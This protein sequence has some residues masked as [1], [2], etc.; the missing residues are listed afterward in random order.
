MTIDRREFL[1][2]VASSALLT[3]GGRSNTGAMGRPEQRA[4]IVSEEWWLNQPITWIQTNL[5]VTDAALDPEKF[6]DAIA[7]FNGNALVIDMGGIF[8]FYPSQ[9]QF[10]RVSPYM[11]KGQDMF[12]EVLRLARARSIRVIGRFDFSK[13]HKDAYIAHHDWFFLKLNGEP[14]IYNDLY[15]TCI[16]GGWYHKKAIEILNEA[17]NRYEVDGLFFNMFGNS[18]RDYSGNPLGL[19]HCAN[20]EEL[21]WKQFHR[22]IPEVPDADY[23]AFMHN[24][25]V[26]VSRMVRSL[27]KAKR[28][29]AALVGTR[30][31][32]IV[33]SESNTA[34]NRPLPLWPYSASDNVNRG[35]NT[36]PQK[37]V[38]NSCM[39]FID[40][41]WRFAM[42]PP[43]EIATRLWQNVANGG[44]PAFT[45]HGT[46]AE[47]EDQTALNVARPIFRQLKEH[48]T[49]YV[50]QYPV[51]RVLLLGAG[52]RGFHGDEDAYRGFFRLLSEDHLPFGVVDNLD[53]L[54]KRAVDLIVA[55]GTVPS[56]LGEWVRNGGHLLM[57][58]ST[59]PPMNMGKVVKVWKDPVGAY[60]RIRDKAMFPSMKDIDIIFMYG[61][62]LQVD[63]KG[64]ITF[65]PPAMFGPPELVDID[66]K[67][68]ED[69]GLIVAEYGKG[70]IAWL[71]WDLGTLYYRQSSE[72]HAL[73]IHDLIDYLLP[74]GRQLRTNAHPL[75][76]ITLMKQGDHHLIHLV[77]ISGHSDTAYFKAIGISKIK[78]EVKGN[79][80]S[81][82]AVMSGGDLAVS[83]S[84]GYTGFVVPTLVDYELINIR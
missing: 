13:A 6:I 73:L 45:V 64:P 10:Q 61:K 21:F 32:D 11:P 67:N 8:A 20:C 44:M 48:Q 72:A 15:S 19:C 3:T 55:T 57:A 14:A 9:V 26:V 81:A 7:D 4:Q 56:E 70:K 50:G 47:Q 36:Y 18:T 71:P 74:Q 51:A 75:V 69:P 2:T 46:L 25:T 77:N 58:G 68:T 42:V 33:Y 52:R 30:V 62:Y 41:P 80:H 23:E 59:E 53:W 24:A 31:G 34:V 49:Y 28:P 35:R 27:I 16:N 12:G 84:D 66:W 78:V 29:E 65:I 1:Q 17:L 76:D 43:A 63:A 22:G 82:R 38:I 39:C 54:G 83:Y 5:R 79:F 37:A 40:F 60:F